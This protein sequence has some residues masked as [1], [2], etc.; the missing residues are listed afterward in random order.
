MV[1]AFARPCNPLGRA[2]RPV[3]AL[4]LALFALALL[5]GCQAGPAGGPRLDTSRP[6][7]VALLVPSGSAQPTDAVLAASLENAARLA[8]EDL[9]GVAIDLR[10]YA[11]AGTEEGAAQA[12]QTA[13]DEGAGIVLGPVYARN[14][15]AAAQAV[16]GRGLSVLSFSNDA[17]IAGNNLFVLGPTFANSAQRL[18]EHAVGTGLSD[19][20]I[21]HDP[22]A[23]GQAGRDALI[24]AVEAAGGRIVGAETY[25]LSQQGVIDAVPAIAE[26]A[27]TSGAQAIFFTADTAGALPLLAQLLPENGVNPEETRFYGLTRWDIPRGTLALEGLQ[28]GRFALPDPILAE[29]FQARFTEAFGT[30]PHPIAGLAYDGIAA[31]GALVREGKAAPLGRASLTQGAGFVGVGGVFRLLPNG[32]NARGLAIAEIRDR[33]V[34]VI[35]PAP[36]RF[37]GAGF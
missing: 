33:A 19:I 5:A 30:P 17:R 24:A 8:I 32:T 16:S 2:L 25:T 4:L 31:I 26:L 7:P 28:G 6:V 23:A 12:A 22:D 37:G 9:Q 14:A 36:R 10:V 34:N 15:S 29:N 13:A 21:V 11:T 20:L 1:A 3:L 27:T 18:A 35:D